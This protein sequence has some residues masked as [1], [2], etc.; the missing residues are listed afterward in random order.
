MNKLEDALKEV[1]KNKPEFSVR[2]QDGKLYVFYHSANG[3]GRFPVGLVGSPNKL[4]KVGNI[5]NNGVVYA[6]PKGRGIGKKLTQVVLNAAKVM[7]RG[8]LVKAVHVNEPKVFKNR[9]PTPPMI[10]IIRKLAPNSVNIRTNLPKAKKMWAVY[11]RIR[12][13][14]PKKSPTPP[15]GPNAK[16][17]SPSP[18]KIHYG[19]RGGQ[20][21]LKG[22]RKVY[23]RSEQV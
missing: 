11:A 1:T 14:S 18:P 22:N 6:E 9:A 20:Y 13:P 3:N 21:T 23:K 15:K 5:T 16:R 7:K 8:V 12:V 4:G 2:H 19:P 10:H 17:L